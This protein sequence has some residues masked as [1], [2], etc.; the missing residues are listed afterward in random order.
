M[1]QT[2]VK[3]DEMNLI[4][5]RDFPKAE[6]VTC[7]PAFVLGCLFLILPCRLF[8]QQRLK[9]L[10]TAMPNHVYHF[11]PESDPI[12]AAWHCSITSVSTGL[13]P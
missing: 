6:S 10:I 9:P 8:S 12:L 4:C 1:Q 2:H 7:V 13:W 11:V 5:F 3:V